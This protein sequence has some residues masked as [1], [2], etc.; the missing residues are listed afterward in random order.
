M[1]DLHL[2]FRNEFEEEVVVRLGLPS[3]ETGDL[4]VRGA[5]RKLL[6]VELALPLA[7]VLPVN[8]SSPR[9]TALSHTLN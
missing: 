1:P 8:I 4:G 2:A 7:V 5:R 9:E 3:C 6:A